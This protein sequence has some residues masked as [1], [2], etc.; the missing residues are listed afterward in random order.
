MKTI[1]LDQF[2]SLL[3]ETERRV[4]CLKKGNQVQRRIS[5][6]KIIIEFLI[7]RSFFLNKSNNHYQCN[8]KRKTTVYFLYWNRLIN[9]LN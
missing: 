3:E 1:N 5:N 9:R 6:F 8:A 7:N 4:K 2:N